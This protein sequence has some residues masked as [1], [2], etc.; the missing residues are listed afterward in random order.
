MRIY[1]SLSEKEELLLQYIWSQDK[2]LTSVEMFHYFETNGWNENNV[3]RT[4]NSLLE[5]KLLNICGM[6]LYTKQYARTFLP[7][8]SQEEYIIRYL[9]ERGLKRKSIAKIVLALA[10]E[11][12]KKEINNDELISQLETIVKELRTEK[13]NRV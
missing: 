7:T 10:K 11:D 12:E 1:N 2:P 5:K 3:F 13:E 9:S 6:E 4:I 8:L